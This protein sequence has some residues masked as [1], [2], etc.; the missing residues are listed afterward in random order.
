MTQFCQSQQLD[1]PG[2]ALLLGVAALIGFSFEAQDE[3][4]N[5]RTVA[6]L[7]DEIA[8]IKDDISALKLRGG[9]RDYETG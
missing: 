8:G 2:V 1:W 6:K 7:S 9:V 4:E 3:P 5:T